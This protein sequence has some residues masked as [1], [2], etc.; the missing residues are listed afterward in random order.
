MT[1][2]TTVTLNNGLEI[3][4][5][6]FGVFQTPPAETIAAVTTALNDGYRLIDTAA[7][8]GNEREV[9]EGIRASG[10]DR[11]DI[12]IESKLWISDY[13][14][15]KAEV[16]FDASLR[17]LGVDYVDLYLLHQP[18]PAD[19]DDTIAAYQL[20]EHKLAEGKVRAIGVA[21][22]SPDHLTRLIDKTT[23]VPAINQVELHPYFTN[24]TVQHADTTLG[25]RTQAW[26]PIGG[27]HRYRP[28]DAP[29]AGNVL[30]HPVITELATKYGKTPAQIVLRWHLEEGRSAIP[31]S[32]HPNRIA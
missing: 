22:F 28:S 6:G 3:P 21:N 27:I 17:R 31:K 1:D 14:D 8:Y 19:F 24:A 29:G 7:S 26:S 16:G 25:I 20:L 12:V 18:T 23:V 30:E 32:T 2:Q 13:A 15:G 9:G 10:I 5:L 11:S 4:A